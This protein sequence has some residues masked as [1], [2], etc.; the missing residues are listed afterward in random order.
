MKICEDSKYKAKTLQ[1]FRKVM[2]SN[3]NRKCNGRDISNKCKAQVHTT[4]PRSFITF[5]NYVDSIDTSEEEK[6]DVGACPSEIGDSIKEYTG[7]QLDF[8][9]TTSS[10]MESHDAAID[11]A[12]D[13]IYVCET[14]NDSTRR[15]IKLGHQQ[16]GDDFRGIA[17]YI[18]YLTYLTIYC[19]LAN[20]HV[21]QVKEEGLSSDLIEDYNFFE[22][23]KFFITQGNEN[24][25]A[26]LP[27]DINT[28]KQACV[29]I[30]KTVPMV[31]FADLSLTQYEFR[32]LISVKYMELGNRYTEEEIRS[33]NLYKHGYFNKINGILRG[34][35]NTFEISDISEIIEIVLNISSAMQ[36]SEITEELLLIRTDSRATEED[37]RIQ[38]ENFVSTTITPQLFNYLLDGVDTTSFMMIHIP[39]GTHVIPMD[40]VSEKKMDLSN[41]GLDYDSTRRYRL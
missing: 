28:L 35:F 11:C 39:K 7:V 4:T 18:E 27:E 33:L 26:S 23:K 30:A 34:N 13:P 37:G 9:I 29:D 15:F 17:N 21:Q 36:K 22:G 1:E 2:N 25:N 12:K 8:F 6:L 41:S 40:I 19:K 38:Y 3:F 24:G 14:L 31:D 10:N 5:L 20:I 16:N 32:K